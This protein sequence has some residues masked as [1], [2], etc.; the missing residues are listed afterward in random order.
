ML[1]F[2][3]MPGRCMGRG[4]LRSAKQICFCFCHLIACLI[5]R[6]PQH[7]IPLHSIYLFRS[8]AEVLVHSK[9]RILYQKWSYIVYRLMRRSA[10]VLVYYIYAPNS[11][12]MFLQD[13]GSGVMAMNPNGL[14]P[15]KN[16]RSKAACSGKARYLVLFF[17]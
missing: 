7:S 11:I 10:Q 1:S 3:T 14:F 13:S 2:V 12:R 9:R 16:N 15:V 8:F 4:H 17:C 5:P 6:H